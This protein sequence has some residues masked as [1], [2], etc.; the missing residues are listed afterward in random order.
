MPRA[1]A[2]QGKLPQ[3]FF[4][5]LAPSGDFLIAAGHR[6]ARWDRA[7]R[8]VRYRRHPLSHP[9]S[10]SI[11]AQEDLVA[12]KSTSGQIQLIAADD[13][14]DVRDLGNRERGEGSN[15]M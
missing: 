4:L 13:G 3:S 10:C 8:S 6:I 11:R 14:A 12:L 2:K 9:A 1:V 15:V 5:E 7:A